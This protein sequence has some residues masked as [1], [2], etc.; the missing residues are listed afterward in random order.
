[1]AELTIPNPAFSQNAG[2]LE[3]QGYQGYYAGTIEPHNQP[4]TCR[5]R[6][7]FEPRIGCD[8]ARGQV[9]LKRGENARIVC[10]NCGD[11]Q[12]F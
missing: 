1:M 4:R 9:F 7:T 6:L 2:K 10:F 3:K 12:I 8:S 11:T 5:Q